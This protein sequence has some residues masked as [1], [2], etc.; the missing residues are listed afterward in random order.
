M[1]NATLNYIIDTGT[2]VKTLNLETEPLY[3][4]DMHTAP[5]LNEE[6]FISHYYNRDKISKFIRENGNVRG[7][8]S[9]TYAKNIKEKEEIP[10]LFN[11][12]G[13]LVLE[14]DPFEGKV[15]EVEK[16]RKLLF[17]SKNQLFTRL[18]LSF[19][20]LDDYLYKLIDLTEKE[21]LY[22][23]KLGIEVINYNNKYYIKFKDLFEYRL[24]SKKLGYLRLAYEDMLDVLK[25]EINEL[26]DNSFYFY[27][28]QFK[29]LINKYNNYINELSVRN[30]KLRRLNINKKYKLSKRNFIRRYYL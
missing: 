18:V 10:I 2:E 5:Y 28:R 16:G 9:M 22:V 23:S 25:K 11:S 30:L 17:N 8:L 12:K 20:L 4:M 15:T 26:D 19:K 14:D 29:Y 24:R 13:E 21:A 6:D 27:I 7:K 3:S 1:N